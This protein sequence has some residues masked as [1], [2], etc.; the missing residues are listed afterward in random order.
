MK[1]LKILFILCLIT[2]C[3]GDVID[4]INNDATRAESSEEKS[5]TLKIDHYVDGW[6]QSEGGEFTGNEE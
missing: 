3:T 1:M 2:A 4:P 5:D 6:K